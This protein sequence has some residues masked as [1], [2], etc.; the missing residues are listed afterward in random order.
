MPVSATTTRRVVGVGNGGAERDRPSG[1]V[2]LDRVG[3]EVHDDL[4][5]PRPIGAHHREGLGPGDDLQEDPRSGRQG[6]ECEAR[7]L[8][9]VRGAHRLGRHGD[10]A[11][12]DPREVENVVDEPKQVLP[13]AQ[14]V[15][16]PLLVAVREGLLP[17]AREELR[18]PEDRVERRPELVA[19]R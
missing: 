15:V 13:A 14:D 3:A 6:L 8:Q 17:I 12:L 5:E 19:H 11:R 16:R 18:E 10:P 7:L 4:R 2:V 1:T 9:D